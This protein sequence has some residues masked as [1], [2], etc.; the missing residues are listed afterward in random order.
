MAVMHCVRHP[1]SF[2]G[3]EEPLHAR[4]V[5]ISRETVRI[6]WNRFGPTLAAA[7]RQQ[8]FPRL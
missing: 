1:M 4:G 3:A 8:P 5:E 2:P 6:W 7:D